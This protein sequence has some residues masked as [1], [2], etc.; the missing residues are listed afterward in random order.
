MRRF[1][2]EHKR[3]LS[4]AKKRNPTG[5][6]KGLPQP[7]GLGKKNKNWKG[8]KVGYSGI[9]KWVQRREGRPSFCQKCGTIKASRFEWANVSGKYKRDMGDWL[10][11]CK[12]CHVRFDNHK[13][14][15]MDK[16]EWVAKEIKKYMKEVRPLDSHSRDTLR[17]MKGREFDYWE[18]EAVRIDSS[19]SHDDF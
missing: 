13:R 18:K 3:K 12:S 11:L 16:P 7:F 4:E 17:S 19:N 15:R 10:R 2:E 5:F 14:K 9:H 6:K 1:T 8:G